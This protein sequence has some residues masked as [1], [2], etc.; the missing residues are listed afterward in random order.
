MK[1]IEVTDYNFKKEGERILLDIEKIVFIRMEPNPAGNFSS[2]G[3]Y[4]IHMSDGWV[5]LSYEDW[6]CVLKYISCVQ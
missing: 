1:F 3:R 4:S 5:A 6:K 2:S